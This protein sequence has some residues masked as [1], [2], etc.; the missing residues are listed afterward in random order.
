MKIIENRPEKLVLRMDANISLANA[1]RRSVD[2][3]PTLA[4]DEV[5]IFKNDSAL[6]DEFLAHR[7][8]L[9]PLKTDNKMGEKTS[10]DLKLVKKGPCTVYSG[11][12][13]GRA[14]IIFDKCPL[15]LLGK[16]QEIE[17]VGTAKIG[18]GT[19]HTKHTPGFCYYRTLSEV[20]SKNPN[21]ERIVK[22]SNRIFTPEMKGTSWICDLNDSE[23]EEVKKLDKEAISESNEIIFFVESFGQIDSKEIF[24]KAVDSLNKNLADFEKALK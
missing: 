10:I 22:N 13:S 11:D 14:D 8:G 12:F 9:I 2:E 6:Y 21:V 23:I 5:E 4:I 3:I 19:D 7:I 24:T 17:L 18:R 15:T 20:K 1:I 16:G